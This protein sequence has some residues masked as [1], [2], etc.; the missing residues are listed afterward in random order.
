MEKLVNIPWVAR[1]QH[2]TQRWSAINKPEVRVKPVCSRNGRCAGHALRNVFISNGQFPS[3]THVQLARIIRRSYEGVELVQWLIDHCVCIQSRSMS[4][5]VWNVLLELG[6]LL[7][8]ELQVKFE[9]SSSLYQ[10][11]FDECEAQSCYFRNE[12]EWQ[13]GVQLLLQ[14]VPCA[15]LRNGAQRLPKEQAQIQR[16]AGTCS[17]VLQMRALERLNSTVQSEL[18]A[19]LARKAQRQSPQSAVAHTASPPQ[20]KQGG[21][22]DGADREELSGLGTVQKLAKDGCGLSQTTPKTPDRPAE[23]LSLTGCQYLRASSTFYK[24]IN[25]DPDPDPDPELN[26][27]PKGLNN[28]FLH[29]IS[30]AGNGNFTEKLRED[31]EMV[32]IRDQWLLE[33]VCVRERGRDA[34]LF[35]RDTSE[36]ALPTPPHTSSGGGSSEDRDKRYATASRTPENV[37]EQL[38]CHVRMEE[39]PGNTQTKNSDSVL[40]DFLLTYLIFMSTNELCQALL[41]HYCSKTCRTKEGEKELLLRKRKILHLVSQW[42]SLCREALQKDQH[43]KLFIKTLYRCVLDDLCEFPTLEKEL[44]ELQKLL[45]LQRRHTVDEYSPNRKNKTLFHQLS[46]KEPWQHPTGT[47]REGREVLCRVYVSMDSYVSIRIQSSVCVGE[48]LSVV[49][50]RFDWPEE[51]LVLMVL[52]YSG[53]KLLLQSQQC[54]SSDWLAAAGRLH[55]CRRDLTGIVNLL[56]DNRQSWQQ[57]VSVLA[58]NSWDVAVALTN[59]DWTLF[60]SLHQQELVYF[61][62]G[63]NACLG[64]TGALELML[65]R[66]NETQ[67]WVMTEV[68][69]CPTL[70]KRVQ[71]FKKFIKIAAHCKAQRNLSAVFSI[72]MGLNTAA[73]SRL[74]Q[75][76]EKVPGRFRKLF[77]ELET[78]TDPSL[79][80][81]AYRDAVKKMKPPKIPFLP[82]LLKDITFIHQGNKTFLDNT[83]NF[84]KLRMIADTVRVVR[85]CQTGHA[86]SMLSQKESP[87]VRAYVR[88][89][90]VIDSQQ[91]LFELSHRLEPRV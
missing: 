49:S 60:S 67:L 29:S 25:P 68:L 6:I 11:T 7:S 1:E 23:W 82:L 2:A 39:N 21:L 80:H 10:F 51:D 9:D 44:K 59:F 35:Q 87:E 48:L 18:V 47:N 91:T 17:P 54:V 57:S 4:V 3:K 30:L 36:R 13:T 31:E 62:F 52:T 58:M 64:H 19:A 63:R 22:A 86:G 83:V 88:Y 72:I 24:A 32:L 40:D 45:Q 56:T 20:V 37:L 15:Q 89:L 71:L 50:E 69:L 78:L 5:A 42:T 79:N 34:V 33:D 26:L 38:L 70:C 85:H 84:E 16:G 74:N 81:K 77:S 27:K 66:W 65:Q 73:V 8:V 46:L 90:H 12:R 76:W 43:T 53:E 41:T 55:A 61:T 14:L 75:T 28:A